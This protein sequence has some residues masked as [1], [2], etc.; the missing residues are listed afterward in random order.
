MA[1]QKVQKL[2]K[3]WKK[4]IEEKAYTEVECVAKEQ[5]EQEEC[6]SDISKKYSSPQM[7]DKE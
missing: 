7:E 4:E 5:A 2:V 6:N 3:K 1:W